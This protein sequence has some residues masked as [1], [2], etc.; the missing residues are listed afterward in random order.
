MAEPGKKIQWRNSPGAPAHGKD[1]PRLRYWLLLQPSRLRTCRGAAGRHV[2]AREAGAPIRR[3][4]RDSVVRRLGKGALAVQTPGRVHIHE[5]LPEPP[6]A[7]SAIG[8]GG[9][10]LH[11]PDGYMYKPEGWHPGRPGAGPAPTITASGVGW[12]AGAT[13]VHSPDG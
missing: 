13:A 7:A 2:R 3:R 5:P 10:A 11:T 8:R 6:P 1:K 4:R 12:L 9:P